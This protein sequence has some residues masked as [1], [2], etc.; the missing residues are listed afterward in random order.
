APRGAKTIAPVADQAAPRIVLVDK[1]GAIQSVIRVGQVMPNGLDPRNFDFDVLNGV[2]GG[3]FTARLNM[4]LREE[5]GW[6]YG[7]G[8]GVSD[9]RGPQVFSVSTS[10]QTDRTAEALNEIA[11]E[12]RDIGGDRPA[13]EK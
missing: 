12:L 10:V 8:S 7:A 2:L 9:A 4:N 5:K 6:T 11:T 3:G 13:T 1:P